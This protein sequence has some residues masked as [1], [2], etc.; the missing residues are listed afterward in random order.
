MKKMKKVMTILMVIALIGTLAAGCSS[1]NKT[2]SNK[3]ENDNSENKTEDNGGSD[4]SKVSEL[5]LQIGHVDVPDKDN[6]NQYFATK[7][8][9][10]CN[11]LSGGAI[12][13]QVM[14]NS[15]LGA[16]RDMVEGMQMGSV[17]M[18]II[19]NLALGNYDKEFQIY[20]LPYLFKDSKEAFS[21]IDSEL[22]KK[23]DS[24]FYDSTGI[25]V[26]AT[27]QGGFRQVI[28]TKH[29]IESVSDF[30]GLKIRVPE[31]DLYLST[32]KSLGANATPLAWNE[33]FTGLQQGAIDGLECP[34]T[35]IYTTG[36]VDVAKYLTI[37]NHI[38][39]PVV[40][41]ISGQ[42]WDGL[43]EE[44]QNIISEASEKA[45]ADQR[46]FI[47]ENDQKLIEKLED[48]GMEVSYVDMDEMREK[49]SDVWKDSRDS[50][51][52]EV[53]DAAMKFLNK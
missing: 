12:D 6:H 31:T 37:S 16:E 42:I 29:P 9:D 50:M 36:F 34:L 20:D 17:D 30:S 10:Y 7:F 39:S 43:D 46:A 23:I 25:K 40:M 19:T 38:F 28:N 24:G 27:G 1:S 32:F 8:A 35:V 11:E 45:S 18:A 51:G 41:M 4:K 47:D 14:G 44:Q 26:L 49:V 48:A 3:T 52:A 33:C 21:L 22:G 53:Y 15:Q 13:V 2:T 5:T